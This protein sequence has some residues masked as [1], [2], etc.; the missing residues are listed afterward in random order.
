[1]K[2][3]ERGGAGFIQQ[4]GGRRGVCTVNEGFD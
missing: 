4:G 3:R 1:M 2:M